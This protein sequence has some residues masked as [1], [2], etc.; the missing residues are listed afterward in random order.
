M[1]A[2]TSPTRRP[3]PIDFCS[4]C[5][6]RPT[7]SV[8]L[9][10]CCLLGCGYHASDEIGTD[11]RRKCR[12]IQSRKSTRTRCQKRDEARKAARKAPP[13]DAFSEIRKTGTPPTPARGNGFHRFRGQEEERP[14]V[15]NSWTWTSIFR[16]LLFRALTPAVH[17]FL[18]FTLS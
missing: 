13:L 9:I 6:V 2:P 18:S 7:S 1:G 16:N 14:T 3:F 12:N 10:V 8:L 17:I 11:V 15:D 4:P 5:E